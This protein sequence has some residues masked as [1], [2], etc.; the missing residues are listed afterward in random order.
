MGCHA[1]N[2][3]EK[4]SHLERSLTMEAATCE[5]LEVK[6]EVNPNQTEMYG[7]IREKFQPISGL[8]RKIK[9]LWRDNDRFGAPIQPATPV[10]E[11]KGKKSKKA[12]AVSPTE[13]L[14]EAFYF[15]VD[16]LNPDTNYIDKSFFVMATKDK[17]V[18]LTKASE[19]RVDNS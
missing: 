14:S 11:T 17:V 16:Y 13:N 7:K 18:D 6:L 3:G 12:K 4:E 10:P 5:K 1:S 19:P 2:D 9:F 8:Q 15:R